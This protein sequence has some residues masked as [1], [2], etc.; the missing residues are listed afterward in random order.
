MELEITGSAFNLWKI[1]RRS[2]VYIRDKV[3]KNKTQIENQKSLGKKNNE[4]FRKH[5]NAKPVQYIAI[6]DHIKSPNLNYK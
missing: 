5:L 6:S 2:A 1:Q 3:I 4:I